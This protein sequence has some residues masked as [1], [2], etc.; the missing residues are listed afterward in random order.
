MNSTRVRYDS[1][2]RFALVLLF[3]F[4]VGGCNKLSHEERVAFACSDETVKVDPTD[5]T[6]PKAIYLCP[7]NTLT[8]NADGHQFQVVF[9]KN[10]PFADDN[11]V[12]DNNHAKSKGAKNIPQLTVYN[13]AITVDGKPVDDPQVVGG[14]GHY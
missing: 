13:Y 6:S 4:G 3:T 7:G 8:W 11:K 14:G 12:F 5:G 1:A 2:I 10:S 9:S